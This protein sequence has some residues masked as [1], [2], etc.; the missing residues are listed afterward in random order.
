MTISL[1]DPVW[2]ILK[3]GFCKE[4]ALYLC[5]SNISMGNLSMQVSIHSFIHEHASTLSSTLA[6]TLNEVYKV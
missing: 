5:H 4:I 6:F 2:F 3:G 1:Q